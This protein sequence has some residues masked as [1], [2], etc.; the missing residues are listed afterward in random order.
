MDVL[1]I[2]GVALA[3]FI[4]V[5]ASGFLAAA[6]VFG[7][8][9]DA[10]PSISG[11][12]S[13]CLMAHNPALDIY[14]RGYLVDAMLNSMNGTVVCTVDYRSDGVYRKVYRVSGDGTLREVS[15][16]QVPRAEAYR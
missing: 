7:T 6:L 15:S 2:R 10:K 16:T 13:V 14:T 1:A 12:E 9:P 3:G 4:L 8:T 5:W 11:A